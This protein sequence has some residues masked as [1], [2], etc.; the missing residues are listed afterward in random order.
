MKSKK[1][2]NVFVVIPAFNEG[3]VLS[4][5]IRTIK[6]EGYNHI[7]A[8]DDGSYDNT[9]EIAQK[10]GIV[11]LRHIINRGVGAAIK[12]GIEAAKILNAKIVVTIDAD[13]Q[14][15]PADIKKIISLI[16]HGND[17]VLGS[18]KLSTDNMPAT[19][20]ISNHIGNFFTWLVYGL[21]VSDSHCGFKGFSKK[22]LSVLDIRNDRYEFVSEVIREIV[23]HKLKYI[24]TRVLVRYTQYSMSKIHRQ[25]LGNSLKTIYRTIVSP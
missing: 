25:N 2:D 12:T 18:R 1:N 23:K 24:E 14:H 13:G 21:W 6:K 4:S 15:D 16:R 7:I 11:V 8:V 19:R 17:V 22:A 9:F 10:E 3:P 20:V 5:T